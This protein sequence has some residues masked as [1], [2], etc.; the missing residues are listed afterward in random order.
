[1]EEWTVTIV[2]LID[3]VTDALPRGA[4]EEMRARLDA[5][6]R[7]ASDA[8]DANSKQC[9]EMQLEAYLQSTPQLQNAAKQYL[10]PVVRTA[11]DNAVEALSRAHQVLGRK[12]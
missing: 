4:S 9:C 2:S 12:T 10:E 7:Q 11:V 5:F 1:M 3:G 6:K 8:C